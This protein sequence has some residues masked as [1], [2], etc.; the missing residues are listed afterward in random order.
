MIDISSYY[1]FIDHSIWLRVQFSRITVPSGRLVA[2]KCSQM[3]YT[4]YSTDL[5][6]MKQKEGLDDSV[7]NKSAMKALKLLVKRGLGAGGRYSQRGE[8]M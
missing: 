6:D 5:K 2:I 4:A 8:N 1:S 3:S 7:V